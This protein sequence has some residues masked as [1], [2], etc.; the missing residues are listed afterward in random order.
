LPRWQ[1]HVAAITNDIYA[2]RDAEF[3]IRSGSLEA[4]RRTKDRRMQDRK[5]RTAIGIVTKALDISEDEFNPDL[6]AENAL[7]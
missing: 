2:R 5:L 1:L 6:S 7:Q 3:V 4:D